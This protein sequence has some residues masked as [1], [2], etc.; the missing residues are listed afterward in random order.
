MTLHASS[1]DAEPT[2]QPQICGPVDLPLDVPPRSGAAS[3][4]P[5][6]VARWYAQHSESPRRSIVSALWVPETTDT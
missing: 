2:P 4:P 3:K 6:T 1:D 5:L